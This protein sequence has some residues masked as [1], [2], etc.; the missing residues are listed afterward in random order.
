MQYK[1]CAQLTSCSNSM[2]VTA[3]CANSLCAKSDYSSSLM[4]PKRKKSG[5]V[6]SQNREGQLIFPPLP[7]AR[8]KIVV[9]KQLTNLM[10]KISSRSVLFKEII[11][12][13]PSSLNFETKNIP[14]ISI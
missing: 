2:C 10:V 6:I 13:R 3:M 1:Q 7:I 9:A 11:S 4:Y 12:K 8:S 5:G 14:N